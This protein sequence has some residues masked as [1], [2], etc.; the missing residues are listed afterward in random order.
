MVMDNNQQDPLQIPQEIRAYLEG[1]LDEAGM[2]GFDENIHQ[3]MINDLYIR[4]D[5]FLI[6]L[7]AQYMPDEKLEEFAK[8]TENNPSQTSV[9]E[10]IQN[11]VPNSKEIFSKA[12]VEFR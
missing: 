3:S 7:I 11:N 10:Y 2:S 9:T 12:F 5:K 4:L 1:I 8:L 6:G